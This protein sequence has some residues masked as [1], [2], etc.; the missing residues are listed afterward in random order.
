MNG[1]PWS[2]S[3]EVFDMELVATAAKHSVEQADDLEKTR[4]RCSVR[5]RVL[6]GVVSR[7]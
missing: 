3:H 6:A 1:H 2:A 7:P 4:R 5:R